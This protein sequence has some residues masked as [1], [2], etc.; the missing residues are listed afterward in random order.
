MAK[1]NRNNIA[2]FKKKIIIKPFLPKYKK[3]HLCFLSIFLPGNKDFRFS[4][5]PQ[6]ELECSEKN[7]KL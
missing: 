4:L 6:S 5:V 7:G 3:S 2:I 1:N